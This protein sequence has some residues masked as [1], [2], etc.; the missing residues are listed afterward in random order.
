M[1]MF[2]CWMYVLLMSDHERGG[3]RKKKDGEKEKT[4]VR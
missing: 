4:K 2:M 1:H 3:R